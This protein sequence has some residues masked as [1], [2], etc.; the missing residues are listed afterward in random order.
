MIVDIATL[1]GSQKL[2]TGLYHAAV[3]TNSERIEKM[4]VEAGQRSGDWVY[5][6]LYAPEFLLPEYDSKIAD[7][8][9]YA[10]VKFTAQSSSAGHF[11]ESHL[12]HAYKG[13][14]LH[15]DMAGQVRHQ[16]RA[17]GFGVGLLY[18]LV[19]QYAIQ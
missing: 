3:L 9:N 18:Q 19:K 12:S 16:E 2:A 4:A 11:I 10:D 17:T 6:V 1:T 7:M 8:K 14:Y 5:P 15:I 13:D